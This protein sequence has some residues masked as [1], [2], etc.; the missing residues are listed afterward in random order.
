MLDM[1]KI[2]KA[3]NKHYFILQDT[4]HEALKLASIYIKS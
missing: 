3:N 4:A 2:L 1:D